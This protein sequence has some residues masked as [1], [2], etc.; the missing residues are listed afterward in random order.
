MMKQS[1]N[2]KKR[3]VYSLDQVCDPFRTFKPM[4]HQSH[5]TKKKTKDRAAR[6]SQDSRLEDVGKMLNYTV[7]C[8]C[9]LPGEVSLT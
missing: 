3:T 4:S 7:P 2:A 9:K 6:F 5:Q 8:V 1:T